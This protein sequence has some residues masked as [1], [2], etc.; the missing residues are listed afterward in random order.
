MSSTLLNFFIFEAVAIAEGLVAIST[1]KP[2]VKAALTNFI[3]SGQALQQA[4]QLGQ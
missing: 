1:L 4:L 2:G 3:A